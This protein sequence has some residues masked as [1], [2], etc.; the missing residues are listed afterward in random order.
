VARLSLA[1]SALNN[2]ECSLN[3]DFLDYGQFLSPVRRRLAVSG[4]QSHKGPKTVK[5]GISEQIRAP[6]KQ[7]YGGS[8]H[9]IGECG[10]R[11]LSAAV[12]PKAVQPFKDETHC[13]WGKIVALDVH[14]GQCGDCGDQRLIEVPIPW[15]RC[16]R[17]HQERHEKDVAGLGP[18]R[19]TGEPGAANVVEA[20]LERGEAA[21]VEGRQDGD[22]AGDDVLII[23]VQRE[24]LNEQVHEA[25]PKVLILINAEVPISGKGVPNSPAGYPAQSLEEVVPA[26]WHEQG[27]T[28][29]KGHEMRS[30]EMELT[31]TR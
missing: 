20:V 2:C 10:S 11:K 18:G 30:M 14:D 17:L 8:T 23:A 5:M 6:L 21:E 4:F 16:T 24:G 22:Q 26:G 27:F 13:I 7:G 25:G 15:E 19:S 1:L 12:L 29:K 28:P 31:L 3:Y 9:L